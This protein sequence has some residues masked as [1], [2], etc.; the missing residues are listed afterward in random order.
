[1]DTSFSTKIANLYPFVKTESQRSS[2]EY[3]TARLWEYDLMSKQRSAVSF[4]KR[5]SG[6]NHNDMSKLSLEERDSIENCLRQN[7]LNKNP[8]Y[9]GKRDVIYLDLHN[10]D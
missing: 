5:V 6:V 1:M 4:C 10:Y 8:E 3:L 7:F 2:P 9:F